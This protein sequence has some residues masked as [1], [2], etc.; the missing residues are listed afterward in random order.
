MWS[1]RQCGVCRND[2]PSD[3]EKIEFISDIEGEWPW[4]LRVLQRS[5]AIGSASPDVSKEDIMK[6]LRECNLQRFLELVPL[7]QLEPGYSLVFAG[8][9]VDKGEGSIRALKFAR[10]IHSNPANAGRVHFIIGNREANKIRWSAEMDPEYYRPNWRTLPEAYWWP[11]RIVPALQKFLEEAQ[12]PNDKFRI[13]QLPEE[14]DQRP[15]KEQIVQAV[16]EFHAGSKSTE[17]YE[18]VI[19]TG[20]NVK[21]NEENIDFAWRMYLNGEMG[22]QNL[23]FVFNGATDIEM[24]ERE[25][26]ILHE[27]DEATGRELALQEYSNQVTADGDM[28][29]YLQ[30][31]KLALVLGKNLFTH[32]SIQPPAKED[33]EQCQCSIGCI[34]GRGIDRQ[35]GLVDWADQLNAWKNEQIAEWQSRPKWET[36]P[37]SSTYEAWQGRGGHALINHGT[38]GALLP[39]VLYDSN[40]A[41]YDPAEK[42]S[43]LVHGKLDA[44]GKV[45]M[46]DAGI[47]TILNGHSPY[48]HIPQVQNDGPISTI[49]ADTSFNKGGENC[50]NVIVT[51]AGDIEIAGKATIKTKDGEVAVAYNMSRDEERW[52]NIGS[53][54][55][56]PEDTEKKDPW[57]LRA[58]LEDGK[59]VF[60][61]Q[62]GFA[63][64]Y[65]ISDPGE[66]EA[67]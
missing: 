58:F 25:L 19:L 51:L 53:L 7:L 49:W 23:P 64:N 36:I 10:A 16:K 8:D 50:H 34:P 5:P 15:S 21:E 47:R 44:A 11:G 48:G 18:K 39:T 67:L 6:E 17:E 1:D 27:C 31:G 24:L 12:K 20:L 61:Q 65:R 37:T 43:P 13:F 42:N 28:T 40:R 9:I 26:R 38:P 14:A 45:Q 46:Q 32:G 57:L 55:V 66:L 29:Y 30:H 59:A 35:M 63:M 62:K 33:P 52:Q 22:S 2:F 54:Y 56:A 4:L 41:L 3:V 60:F